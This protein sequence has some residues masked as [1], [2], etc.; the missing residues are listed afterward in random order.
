MA[1]KTYGRVEIVDVINGPLSST[2]YYM[3]DTEAELPTSGVLLGDRAFSIDTK[4]FMICKQLTPYVEWSEVG[5]GQSGGGG[6]SWM[7]SG[8]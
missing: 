5:S 2:H 4:K 3:C 1:V 6:D 8:W 7:P